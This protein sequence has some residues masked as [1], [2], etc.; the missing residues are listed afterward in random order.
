MTAQ[1]VVDDVEYDLD[2]Q[3]I[4]VNPGRLLALVKE[5]EN[6]FCHNTRCLFKEGTQATTADTYDY[7]LGGAG[8][9]KIITIH[10]A[11]YGVSGAEEPMN[12]VSVNAFNKISD[13]YSEVYEDIYTMVTRLTMRLFHN[14]TTAYNIKFIYSYEPNTDITKRASTL[15]LDDIYREALYDYC[16]WKS[17]AP[18]PKFVELADH[19]RKLY[20]NETK[21]NVCIPKKENIK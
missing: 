17:L 3:G 12:E 8:T 15:T 13:F 19:Y 7:A 2:L 9:E 18:I 6:N 14:P 21:A 16:M 20:M 4:V 5:A 11:K 1:D 10:S